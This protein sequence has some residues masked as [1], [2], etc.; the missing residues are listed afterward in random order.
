MDELR[1]AVAAFTPAAVQDVTGVSAET[2]TRLARELCGAPT[3]AVY[4]RIG[5]N[6]VEFGTTNAWLIDAI[7]VLTGNIDSRGG[8]MFTTPGTGSSTT[9]GAA[10]K[11]KG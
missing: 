1:D 6:T 5:V 7:N 3:A 11:G 10:G 9:R 4:G 8:A 2:T